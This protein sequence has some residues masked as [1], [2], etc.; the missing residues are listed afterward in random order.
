MHVQLAWKR[1]LH[2]LITDKTEGNASIS[3]D[4][5]LYDVATSL[6]LGST[7]LTHLEA[8]SA[9]DPPEAWSAHAVY[10]LNESQSI[11]V[12]PMDPVTEVSGSQ[13]INKSAE[14]KNVGDTLS[15]RDAIAWS[16]NDCFFNTLI[17][18]RTSLHSESS[19]ANRVDRDVDPT[20]SRNEDDLSDSFFSKVKSVKK[21][22]LCCLGPG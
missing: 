4:R 16:T 5:D 19:L 3:S 17:K 18:R 13:A 15:I 14:G 11:T 8:D 22:R 2:M 6:T 20:D 1:S 12:N 21:V 10:S 7:G 9:E